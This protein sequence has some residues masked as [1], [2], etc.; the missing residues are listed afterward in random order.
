MPPP[1]STAAQ[2][3]R[4]VYTAAVGGEQPNEAIAGRQAPA[5]MPDRWRDVKRFHISARHL[6]RLLPIYIFSFD[7][8][9]LA[10]PPRLAA[11][12]GTFLKNFSAEFCTAGQFS[13]GTTQSLLT[14]QSV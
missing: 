6:G 7:F 9:V 2:Q 13:P 5:S 14:G 12:A 8:R 11:L 1:S 4:R 3:Q 10:R